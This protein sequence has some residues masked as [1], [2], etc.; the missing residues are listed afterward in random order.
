MSWRLSQNSRAEDWHVELSR[1][2][3]GLEAAEGSGLDQSQVAEET[4]TC[5]LC[6]HAQNN[7][8]SGHAIVEVLFNVH[9]DT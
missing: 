3:R 7:P 1:C 2:L 5:W 8:A 9:L 4:T 6:L